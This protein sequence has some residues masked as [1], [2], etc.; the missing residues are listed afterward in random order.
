MGHTV[1]LNS[2][3]TFLRGAKLSE[4][5]DDLNMSLTF[6]PPFCSICH[7]T[8]HFKDI[9]CQLY[10]CCDSAIAG[11]SSVKNNFDPEMLTIQFYV[12]DLHL[13]LPKFSSN[14]VIS[15]RKK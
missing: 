3:Y 10:C 11:G 13:V 5:C 7:T 15:S 8:L 6:S 14:V 9:A 4:V 2:A 1:T 12:E